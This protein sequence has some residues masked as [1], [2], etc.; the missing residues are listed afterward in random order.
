MKMKSAEVN[1]ERKIAAYKGGKDLYRQEN[2]PARNFLARRS[3]GISM[4]VFSGDFAA[5][6]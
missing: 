4:G 5:V 2:G 6:D 1:G 3:E